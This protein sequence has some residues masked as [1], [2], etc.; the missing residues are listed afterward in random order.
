MKE[1]KRIPVKYIRDYIKKEYKLKD[2]C[3]ICNSTKNLELHHL[4]S[5]SQLFND[6]CLKNKIDNTS[7][8]DVQIMN[9]IRENF[10]KDEKERL[11]NEHL[12]TLCKVHH[13]RLHNIYG[14]RYS[15]SMV[16]KILN[17]INIQRDK[18]NG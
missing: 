6:W 13:E 18:H 14:Q 2:C 16:P 8:S 11:S 3:Y 9:N 4:F 15:N 12:Y 1:L 17:W 10:S 7:I 5:V